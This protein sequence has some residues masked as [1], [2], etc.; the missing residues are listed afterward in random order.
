MQFRKTMDVTVQKN[1]MGWQIPTYTAQPDTIWSVLES[2]PISYRSVWAML[3]A[4][5]DKTHSERLSLMETWKQTKLLAQIHACQHVTC[6]R[7]HSQVILYI[8]FVSHIQGQCPGSRK[9][10]GLESWQPRLRVNSSHTSP[11]LPGSWENFK[12]L[13]LG[14]WSKDPTSDMN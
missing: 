11:M 12:H 2:T 13:E 8:G 4:L 9:R 1:C 5:R 6:L 14:R 3:D 7:L 10:K